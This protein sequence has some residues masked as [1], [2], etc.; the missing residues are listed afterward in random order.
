MRNGSTRHLLMWTMLLLWTALTKGT[1]LPQGTVLP[2]WTFSGSSA[3]MAQADSS[4]TES[5]VGEPTMLS[6]GEPTMAN[7]A[8]LSLSK[9]DGTTTADAGVP[10]A[11]IVF[12][13]DDLPDPVIAGTDLT[14]MMSAT[15][16]GPAD[17]LDVAISDPLPPNTTFVSATPSVGGACVTPAVG[18]TGTVSCTWPGVT[19]A[20]VTRTLTL[21]VR[22]EFSAPDGST[23]INIANL[24]SSVLSVDAS[25]DT[26]VINQ[27]NLTV[28]KDDIADPVTAGGE[29]TYTI[30]ATNSGPAGAPDVAISDPL[31]PNTTF[32]SAIP[33]AG[34][35]CVTPAVGDGGTVSCTWAGITGV[36]IVR[37]LTLVARVELSAPDGSTITNTA[38]AMPSV[39]ASDASADTLVINRADLSI[40]KD[41]GVTTAVPGG[42]TTYTIRVENAAGG[43]FGT[44]SI[45]GTDPGSLFEVDLA[46]GLANLIGAPPGGTP[47]GMS[48]VSVD[49]LTGTIYAIHGAA[50]RGA[51]LL[52]LDRSTGADLSRVIVTSSFGFLDGSDAL[53]HD[54]S[55]T[56]F[57][58]GWLEGRLMTLDPSTGVALSDVG[59]TGGDTNN[60]LS[61]LAFDPTTGE[62]WSSRGGSF[63]GRLVRLDPVTAGVLDI[64]DVAG[65]PAITAIAFDSAGVLFASLGG[66]RLATID[67]TT[68][69]VT[70]IGTG[71]GGPKIAGLGFAPGGRTDVAG[72]TVT[73]FFPP[74]LSCS[75]TCVARGGASCTAG[76]VVGDINDVVDIPSG[77]SL[78]YTAVC[79]IDPAATGILTNTATVTNP[80]GVTDPNPGNNNSTDVDTL[81]PN[82]D[83]SVTKVDSRDPAAAGDPLSYT[84][85]V[86]NAG[87]SDATLVAVTDTLPTGVTFVSTSGCLNDPGGVPICD[88]GAI[89]AGGLATYTLNVNVDAST[90]SGIMTNVVSVASATVD[91]QPANNTDSED[92]QVDADPPIVTLV[93]SVAG[94]GDGVLAECESTRSAITQLLVSFNEAVQDPPGNTDPSDVTNPANYRL[95]AAGPDGDFATSGC[96][97]PL[98][99]DSLVP[100]NAVAYTAGT[101]TATVDVNNGAPLADSLHR[102][103]AC[104]STSIRDIAGNALDGNFDGVRGDDFVRTYRVDRANLFDNGH[105]DCALD[106]WIT[107]STNPAEIVHSSDDVQASSVSG[108]AAVAN[109]TASSN[110]SLGQCLAVVAEE[111]YTLS[112]RLRLAAAP[113]VLLFATRTCEFFSAPVCAGTLL[114]SEIEFA[115]LGD[116][117]GVWK[118]FASNVVTPA[119]TAS[120]LCSFDL[121][122]LS[123]ADFDAFLDDL[124]L[125]LESAIFAHDFESG[126]I[127]GWSSAQ[128]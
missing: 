87:P 122:T 89:P 23:I 16:N 93:G 34:G 8:G 31:P 65:V 63:A 10:T 5:S 60:H 57:A 51:E 101:F 80:V 128:P 62:L 119:G 38:S 123:G 40:T 74:E 50:T 46:T 108:S 14:Y 56:L 97:P 25:A 81:T 94:T 104:G 124:S 35:A 78:T 118:P 127:L 69:L 24:A 27:A 52:T 120:A 73:D 39:L 95:V 114:L 3:A 103:L 113:G 76:P 30:T 107:L 84:V 90:P 6:V 7:E 100:V 4:W 71:F 19:G 1:V 112:G 13:K 42:S 83:L 49:P 72:A 58:G 110:F 77:D 75:W 91:P 32:V 85:T 44:S 79:A 33:S 21:V 45:Q 20:A 55:G 54:S 59:V 64:V 126:D 116:T 48:D 37:T 105:F 26:L 121:T 11:D 2:P 82:A 12:V 68:E 43:L 29:V 99:D 115:F 111:S 109:L 98:G 47:N 53:A 22:V 70:R 92:T 36:G 67:L 125:S 66:N 86:N 15:N 96:G 117:A 61:D 28:T 106:P 88:L 41:D 17:A 9:D 102:L 18:A